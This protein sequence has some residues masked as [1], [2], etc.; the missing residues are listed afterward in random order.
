MRISP[1]LPPKEVEATAVL[2]GVSDTFSFSQTVYLMANR[3]LSPPSKTHSTSPRGFGF[4]LPNLNPVVR[5]GFIENVFVVE[6]EA[7]KPRLDHLSKVLKQ[8]Q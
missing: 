2:T 6:V 1:K 5:S 8:E 3:T 4:S 7:S